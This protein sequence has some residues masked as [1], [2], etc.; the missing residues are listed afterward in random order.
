ME[1]KL[2]NAVVSLIIAVYNADKYLQ[3]CL[4][5]VVKQTYT[6]LEIILV[7]DSSTDTSRKICD[8]YAAHDR[9]IIVI[10]Q[11]NAGVSAARNKALAVLRVHILPL[12]M[13][14]TILM[15]TWYKHYLRICAGMVWIWL[16]V[17]T[18]KKSSLPIAR[19]MILNLKIRLSMKMKKSYYLIS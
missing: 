12:L 18:R 5:S 7:D 2:N 10:H 8:T 4:D 15:L 13:L 9:R 6:N 19:R 16:V 17:V 1:K 11:K 14:M 3:R